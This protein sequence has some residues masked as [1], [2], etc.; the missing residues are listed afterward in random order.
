MLHVL[1]LRELMSNQAKTQ[2][3]SK[4]QDPSIPLQAHQ[5]CALKVCGV[6]CALF[7]L[8]V[9]HFASAHRPKPMAGVM[10]AAY[11]VVHVGCLGRLGEI[12]LHQSHSL[13]IA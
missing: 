13:T 11:S 10:P 5:R 2:E 8:T 9:V 7:P 1:Y 12:R 6:H 4:T 3:S